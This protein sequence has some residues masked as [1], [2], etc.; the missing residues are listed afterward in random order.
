MTDSETTASATLYV[1]ATPIGNLADITLRALEVLRTV[2][3][4]AAED[5]R[6]SAVLLQHHGITTPMR[7]LHDFSSRA[8]VTALVKRL[9]AGDSVALIA[10]AGTPTIS[11]PGYTLVNAARAAGF[12]VVPIPGPSAL[13]AALSVAGLPTQGFCFEGFLP[14]RNA[15]RRDRLSVLAPFSGVRVFYESPHRIEAMLEDVVDILGGDRPACIARELTKRFETI[16]SDTAAGCLA[17]VRAEPVHRK[18]EFVVLVGAESQ[19]A[20]QTRVLNQGVA[21]LTELLPA[22]PVRAAADLAARLTGAP[23]NALY[24]AALARRQ[25]DD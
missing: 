16:L 2:S 12:P 21:V 13:I 17:Y 6:H 18:G 10:D 14:A 5:T 22:M 1:V 3:C 20:R 24:A 11:D 15:A 4:I 8:A 25:A 23:R 9:Q 19:E 7:A